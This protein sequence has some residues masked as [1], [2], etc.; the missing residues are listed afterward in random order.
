LP[1]DHPKDLQGCELIIEAV[2]ENREVKAQVT[3]E[4][5]EYL[6]RGGFMASNTSTLPITSLA[7]ACSR[8][9]KFIGI[10]FFSPVDKMRL[11][12]II[13]GHKTDAETVARAFDYV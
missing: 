5:E 9:E 10:H 1:T 4:A 7:Q 8:P 12:E 2:Y 6:A 3:R 13:R 11:V